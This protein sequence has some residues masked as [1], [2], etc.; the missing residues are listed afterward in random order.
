MVYFSSCIA[1]KVN[2]SMRTTKLVVVVY[3]LDFVK[4]KWNTSFKRKGPGWVYNN[5]RNVRIE[6]V[7]VLKKAEPDG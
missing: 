1:K 4:K 2:T 7:A 3:V 5:Y 6:K